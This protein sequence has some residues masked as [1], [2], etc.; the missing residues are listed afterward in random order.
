M[1]LTE[2]YQVHSAQSPH[3]N[4]EGNLLGW[5]Q[6]HIGASSVRFAIEAHRRQTDHGLCAT[7]GPATDD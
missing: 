1:V 2:Q 6:R 4:A 7:S 5:I 3:R